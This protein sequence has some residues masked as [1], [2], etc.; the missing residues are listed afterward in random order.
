MNDTKNEE[1]KGVCYRRVSIG[2]G[3]VKKFLELVHDG[4]VNVEQ[5]YDVNPRFDADDLKKAVEDEK[6]DKYF[7]GYALYEACPDDTEV[8]L[9]KSHRILAVAWVRDNVPQPG[10]NKIERVWSVRKGCGRVLLDMLLNDAELKTRGAVWF[11]FSDP[12]WG[13]LAKYFNQFRLSN[14]AFDVGEGEDARTVHVRSNGNGRVVADLVEFVMN[15]EKFEEKDPTMFY[16]NVQKDCVSDFCNGQY[17]L[18][19]GDAEDLKR[20]CRLVEDGL[21]VRPGRMFP[22]KRFNPCNLM[23][24][25][26]DIDTD[27]PNFVGIEQCGDAFDLYY[28]IDDFNIPDTGETNIG[29]VCVVHRDYPERGIAKVLEIQSLYRGYGRKLMEA[30]FRKFDSVWL[31]SN[32]E[33]GDDLVNYYASLDMDPVFIK[34]DDGRKFAYF[35]KGVMRNAD[36]IRTAIDFETKTADEIREIE[37]EASGISG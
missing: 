18:L 17:T 36:I 21:P 2:P 31:M 25:V 37:P 6:T 20:I 10:L 34:K 27:C 13:T 24:Y 3:R 30:L 11:T 15:G 4:K 9:N 5:P 12:I 23:K 33:G 14:L 8:I 26:R 1:T 32:P 7:F 28:L 35:V 22:N 16:P 29:A 19:H